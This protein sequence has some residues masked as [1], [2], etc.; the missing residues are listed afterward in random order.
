M[1]HVSET[2]VRPPL[3]AL[4]RSRS[5]PWCT[6]V[7][8][9]ALGSACGGT[10]AHPDG[11]S[12]DAAP[13]T[14]SGRIEA[15]AGGHTR[16]ASVGPGDDA[17]DVSTPSRDA[18]I[19]DAARP[20]D[21]SSAASPPPFPEVP[22]GGKTLSSPRLVTIVASNDVPSDG[23]D[24]VTSLQAFSD[25]LPSSQVWA[26]VSSE[27]GLGALSSASHLTGPAISAGSYTLDQ[28]AAYV[29]GVVANDAGSS[30]DGS[31]VYVVYLPTGGSLAEGYCATHSAYPIATSIGDEVVAIA[32][33]APVAQ[34]ET[35][36][37][38]LTRGATS[39]IIDSITDPLGDGY[40]LAAP[41]AKPW[42][43]SP[44]L[45]SGNVYLGSMCGGTRIFES[46]VGGPSG[47]WELSRI[48][49][50][51]AAA[52]GGDPCVPAHDDPYYTV[53]T[54]QGWYSVQPGG[55]V[56]IP[57]TGW[58]EAATSN[59]LL[60]PY[61]VAETNDPTTLDGVADGGIQAT[62]E[63]GAGTTGDCFVRAALNDGTSGTVDVT[64]PATAQSGDYIVVG[65]H[66]FRED[67]TTCEPPLTEDLY[68]FWPVGVYVP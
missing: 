64:V 23:T 32:R 67:P 5:A 22:S 41:P 17:G 53:T 61:H 18:G 16:E 42:T 21:G 52:K 19:V 35:Q 28:V 56:K 3:V 24:T 51:A 48:W 14:D 2:S 36:L 11:D 33:C 34:S 58:S 29:A 25:F 49:S 10:L 13:K 62:S 4:T 8:A 1:C 40:M 57:V 15:G 6:A 50:N 9:A 45:A 60:S 26:A 59:W 30:T 46:S 65:L 12:V 43:A 37:G 39:A 27:Y 44:W 7:L 68:H 55:T 47:G 66:S 63:A 31:T 20:R 38:E 54:P